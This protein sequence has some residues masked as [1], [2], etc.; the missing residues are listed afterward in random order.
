VSEIVRPGWRALPQPIQGFVPVELVD[1]VASR[2]EADD[3]DAAADETLDLIDDLS[4]RGIGAQPNHIFF[5]DHD[6][7][8]GERGPLHG[9]PFAANPFAAN[10]FAAN[11]FA[12]NPF[13]ANPFAANPFAANPFAANPFAANPFAAEGWPVPSQQATGDRAHSAIPAQPPSTGRAVPVSDAAPTILVLDTGLPD[14]TQTPSLLRHAESTQ[15]HDRPDSDADDRLDPVAGHGMFIAGIITRLA[16]GCR[17]IVVPVLSGF[18]DGD[19]VAVA[20]ALSSYVGKVDVV[21]LSFGTYSPSCPRVLARAVRAVQ[22]GVVRDENDNEVARRPAVVVASA[23]NDGTWVPSFP[24]SLPGVISVAALDRWGPAVFSNYG[25]WVRAC[26]AGTSVV[27][28]FFLDARTDQGDQFEGWAAW[29]GTSF[30]APHVAGA[31]AQAMQQGGLSSREAVRRVID[32]PSLLR[33]PAHG[34][35]VNVAPTQA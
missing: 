6:P 34:T 28:T 5:A 3:A 10:P 24:A 2:S 23:G 17:V 18:G 30:A 1:I 25:P 9:N 33:I 16:P 11:P 35:V 19:E 21:N 32:A 13:A 4:S 12:A 29:S 7:D 27:S 31:L 15:P 14:S 22:K 8:C 20:A 26:A